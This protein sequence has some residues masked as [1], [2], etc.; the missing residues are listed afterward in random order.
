MLYEGIFNLFPL[1][2]IKHG[3]SDFERFR[4][5]GDGRLRSILRDSA[6]NNVWLLTINQDL[7]HHLDL[8]GTST[9]NAVYNFKI[10][11]S[12]IYWVQNLA[13]QAGFNP[14]DTVSDLQ[15]FNDSY[16]VENATAYPTAIPEESDGLPLFRNTVFI[17]T[18]NGTTIP[19]LIKDKIY[20]YINGSWVEE[21]DFTASNAGVFTATSTYLHGASDVGGTTSILMYSYFNLYE[22]VDLSNI[23]DD[24][25]TLAR[26]GG[27]FEVINGVLYWRG[28]LLYEQN[29]VTKL[30]WDQYS[31]YYFNR[32]IIA[33]ASGSRL[34]TFVNAPTGVQVDFKD[35]ESINVNPISVTVGENYIAVLFNDNG[36]KIAFMNISNAG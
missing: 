1:N 10:I 25:G 18:K 28:A 15:C 16:G 36:Y 31:E 34:W 21:F 27:I 26:Y 20:S 12:S 24:T 5:S 13:E 17:A 23:N 30:R 2:R 9:R 4:L 22:P 33:K 7:T 3:T 29:G 14:P 11:G 32:N 19:G 35:I 6:N 8:L